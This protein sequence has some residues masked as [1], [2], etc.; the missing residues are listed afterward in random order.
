M[1]IPEK[2]LENLEELTDYYLETRYP[3]IESKFDKYIS[4]Q[5]VVKAGEIIKWIKENL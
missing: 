4:E 1:K 2:F 3:D 5:A